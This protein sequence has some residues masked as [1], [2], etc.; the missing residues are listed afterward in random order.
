MNTLAERKKMNDLDF[1]KAAR[2]VEQSFINFLSQISTGLNERIKDLL[3]D[4][5]T[6]AARLLEQNKAAIEA[7]PRNPFKILSSFITEDKNSPTSTK[8]IK[9]FNKGTTAGSKARSEGRSQKRSRK[10]D[11]SPL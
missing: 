9:I 10:R 2:K 11:K 1:T 5:E 3:I 7:M 8:T 6:S 4:E